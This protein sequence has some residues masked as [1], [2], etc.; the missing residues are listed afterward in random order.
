MI[1][2]MSAALQLVTAMLTCLF[3]SPA[4]LSDPLHKFHKRDGYW[5]HGSGWVFP[6]KLGEFKLIDQPTQIAGNDDVSAEY[7]MESNGE[8]RSAVVDVYYPSSAAAGAKFVTAQ[9]DSHARAN[10]GTC[11]ALQSEGRFALAQQPEI[12]GVKVAFVPSV[13][14]ECPQAALYFFQTPNW[15]ISVRTTASATDTDAVR[16]LEEFVRMLPWETL[17]TDPFLQDLVP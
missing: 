13:A 5:H 7:A 8:R 17:D 10:A 9:A 11:T 4:A 6:S 3:F 2:R 15:V 1:Q 16:M 14:K 12:V